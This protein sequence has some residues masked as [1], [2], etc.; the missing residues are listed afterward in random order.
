[1]MGIWVIP[2]LAIMYNAAMNNSVHISLC[3]FAS[4]SL[5]QVPGN[6]TAGSKG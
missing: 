3:V 6:R 1:M 5:G 2:T 4:V